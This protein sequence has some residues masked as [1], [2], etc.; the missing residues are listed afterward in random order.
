MMDNLCIFTANIL[1]YWVRKILV[2]FWLIRIPNGRLNTNRWCHRFRQRSIHFQR[3]KQVWRLVCCVRFICRC[4]FK[5]MLSCGFIQNILYLKSSFARD[6]KNVFSVYSIS[7]IFVILENNVVTAVNAE[8]P[9]LSLQVVTNKCCII[10]PPTYKIFITSIENKY[11][12]AAHLGKPGS[13][14]ATA[15]LVLGNSY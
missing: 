2:F 9:Q 8:R 11:R 4:I 10:L 15:G 13:N 12:C 7:N 14:S 3:Y 6:L 1:L 5:W